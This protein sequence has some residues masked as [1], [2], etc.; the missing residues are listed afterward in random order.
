VAAWSR[1]INGTLAFRL[2]S[3]TGTPTG[4]DVFFAGPGT[5]SNYSSLYDL[6]LAAGKNGNFIITATPWDNGL[7]AFVFNNSG[8]SVNF[9][10]AANIAID[11]NTMNQYNNIGVVALA[12][13][14]F[15]TAWSEFGSAYVKIISSTG[16]T[17]VNSDFI[18]FTYYPCMVPINT[19]GSEGF[20]LVEQVSDDY[21][22][23]NPYSS[24]YF[25]KFNQ[26]GV[27]QTLAPAPESS[28]IQPKLFMAPGGSSGFVYLY[29]Y[30]KNYTVDY[31]MM[32][33]SPTG[34]KDTKMSTVD[35]V[36][37]STLPV[38]LISYDAK[39]LNNQQVQLTWKTASENN[40]SHFDVEKST[41]GR[42]FV[43]I[44]R[45]EAKGNSN[46]ISDYSFIDRDAITTN[47]YYRLR[48]FD[49]DGKSKDLGT[50]LVR[51]TSSQTLSSVYPNPVQ[52][53]SITLVAG[54]QPLPLPYRITDASGKVIKSGTL[55]QQQEEINLHISEGIYFLQI[56][57]QVIKIKK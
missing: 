18:D 2:I 30:Y 23:M 36:A 48:Q 19:A 1:S 13:G 49:I 12:N 26:N 33:S 24:I 5:T 57:K 31:E 42:T 55:R 41:D 6:K 10:G 54:D 14:N 3:A 53:N 29:Q 44:G 9:N 39:L 50:K 43:K 15:A 37:M 17:V 51:T 45:V 52:G 32:Y 16:A 56:G 22:M 7:R 40:S 21:D 38:S 25:A 35:F 27:L 34:D 47:T 46:T 28:L 20:M 4:S 11:P 8:V